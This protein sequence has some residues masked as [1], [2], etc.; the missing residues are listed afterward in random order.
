MEITWYVIY[1]DVNGIR[2]E[3]RHGLRH[4]EAVRWAAANGIKKPI[5]AYEGRVWNGR[6]EDVY[7]S[8]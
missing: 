6:D 4:E 7:R 8:R 3:S 2:R 1:R 5:F